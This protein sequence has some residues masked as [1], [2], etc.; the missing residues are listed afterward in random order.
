ML[1]PADTNRPVISAVYPDGSMLLQ[2]TNTFHFTVSSSGAAISDSSIDLVLDGVNVSANLTISGSA[3]EKTVT[4]SGLRPNV[5]NY[6]AVISVTNANGITAST[7]VHFDT[8]SPS[9]YAWE[10]EDYDYNG[11]QFLDNPQVDAYYGL[12]GTINVDFKELFVNTPQVAYRTQDPMGTDK[13]GDVPRA[14]FTGTND[15]NLGWFTA[16]EWVNFTRHYPAGNYHVYGRLSR[17]TGTNAAPVLSRVTSGVG[18]ESQ[19]TV[20]VGSFSVDS[21]GWGAYQ[22]VLLKNASSNPVTLALNGNTATFRLTSAGPEANTEANANFFMLV[23]AVPASV[24]ISAALDSGNMVLSFA[25]E[26]GFNYQVQY[27][28]NLTDSTWNNL[29]SALAGNGAVQSVNEPATGNNR[30]YRLQIQ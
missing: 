27:K 7:T 15:Y 4:Y 8:F 3:N 24:S 23:P 22:W 28:N 14:R 6:T 19:T 17:G 2:N 1:V 5:P 12:V 10:A 26:S 20:D 21:H 25:T 11:G 9:L 30:F 29:G 13:T 16:G 18:T